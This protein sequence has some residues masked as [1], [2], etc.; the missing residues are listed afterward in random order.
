MNVVAIEGLCFAGKST[1]AGELSYRLTTGSR[2][3]LP[4]YS[5]FIRPTE[6]PRVPASS[7]EAEL[8]AFEYYLSVEDRRWRGVRASTPLVIEDRSV[9]TLLAHVYANQVEVGPAVFSFAVERVMSIPVRQRPDLVVYLDVNEAV[10]LRRY[11]LIP[12]KISRVFKS[13]RYM[14]GFRAYFAQSVTSFSKI[15]FV[16]ANR[17]PSEIADD[18]MHLLE[19]ESFC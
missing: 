13:R 6:R 3:V 18:V 4:D 11:R 1:L 12:N 16:D 7:A 10:L 15:V 8:A 2:V 17:M 14:Q 5:D 19:V 9:H